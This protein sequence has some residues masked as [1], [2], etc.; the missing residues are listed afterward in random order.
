MSEKWFRRMPA[1]D[2]QTTKELFRWVGL[3]G[4]PTLHPS[5]TN[6]YHAS[7]RIFARTLQQLKRR[8]HVFL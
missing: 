1:A 6:N 2:E 4:L 7:E 8:A 3:E 5:D